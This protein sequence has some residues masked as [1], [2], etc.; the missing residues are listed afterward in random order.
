MA[1]GA[2]RTREAALQSPQPVMEFAFAKANLNDVLRY[3]ARQ[4]NIHLTLPPDDVPVSNTAVT[5]KL[6]TTPLKALET[7][8][9]SY[10]L[11]LSESG[12]RWWA[13][14]AGR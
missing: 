7:V 10:G 9:R 1:P 5:F 11:Q 14:P 4:A 13:R 2:S 12:G 3:L 6:R 8:T